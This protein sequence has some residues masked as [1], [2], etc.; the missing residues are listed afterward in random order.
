MESKYTFVYDP[1]IEALLDA[2]LCS[3]AEE[4]RAH[5]SFRYLKFLILGGGYGRGEGGILKKEN[6][7]SALYNDLDF[8]VISNTTLSW[9]NNLLNKFYEQLAKKWRLRL[10]IDVDFSKA[11]NVKYIKKR[12]HIMVWKEMIL[13]PLFLIGDK[14]E[15]QK[16]FSTPSLALPPSEAA[17]LL[18]NRMSGLFLAK[19]RLHGSNPLSFEDYDFIA[20]NTSKAVLAC[21]DALLIACEKYTLS[22]QERLQ[23]LKKLHSEKTEGL[24]E[25]DRKSVV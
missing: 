13:S 12:S 20:R 5:P 2:T 19:Q 22:I 3:I 7:E 10:G 4:A 16:Y 15:F 9:R 6:G 8:F 24:D 14:D 17:K 25:L 18:V 23:C 21:G 1:R 11:R